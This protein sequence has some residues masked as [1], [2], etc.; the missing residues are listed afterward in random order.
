MEGTPLPQLDTPRAKQNLL[1][2][3]SGRVKTKSFNLTASN[4]ERKTITPKASP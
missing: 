3:S 2:V 1:N 4:E